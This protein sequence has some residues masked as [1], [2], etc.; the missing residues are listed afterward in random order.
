MGERGESEVEYPTHHRDHLVA[1]VFRAGNGVDVP[2]L[3]LDVQVA[4]EREGVVVRKQ[5][6]LVVTHSLS[7][8]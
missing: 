5:A 7:P 1:A 3:Y 8:T 6:G 2:T 4:G